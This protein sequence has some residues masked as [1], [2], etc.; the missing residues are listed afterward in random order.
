[1][2]PSSIDP[3]AQIF[4]PHMRRECDN[5]GVSPNVFKL[6]NATSKIA[7]CA[8]W[9]Q[10]A[11]AVRI[12][13]EQARRPKGSRTWSRRRHSQGFASGDA[14]SLVRMGEIDA[15]RDLH[16][17][18]LKGWMQ[19][20][21]NADH[22]RLPICDRRDNGVGALAD[23]SQTTNGHAYCRAADG[24]LRFCRSKLILFV[25]QSNIVACFREKWQTR[26][27]VALHA[28]H[29]SAK[30][31]DD[32]YAQGDLNHMIGPVRGEPG[33]FPWSGS[34]LATRF[35][36]FIFGRCGARAFSRWF[37]L[38]TFVAVGVRGRSVTSLGNTVSLWAILL[39]H[40]SRGSSQFHMAASSSETVSAH[41]MCGCGAVRLAGGQCISSRVKRCS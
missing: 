1:M 11:T 10:P 25:P 20:R 27:Q 21:V 5:R 38:Y 19:R 29:E 41:P 13:V 34:P 36:R 37:D 8:D 14:S 9:I 15:W 24:V 26:I 39:L 40:N 30:A 23:S 17:C 2:K 7:Y 32:C 33:L 16:Q 12:E 28:A 6:G 18:Q 35:P 4:I 22:I 3:M 31:I